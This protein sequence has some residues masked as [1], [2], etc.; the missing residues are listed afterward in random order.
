[1]EIQSPSSSLTSDFGILNLPDF[2]Y[3]PKISTSYCLLNELI[4]CPLNFESFV[5][6]SLVY[7][8]FPVVKK[9][10]DF[11][12]NVPFLKRASIS[13]QIFSEA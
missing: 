12:F 1:M 11:I 7:P 5:M 10:V 13:R 3:I 4:V 8:K 6:T 9:S 2:E